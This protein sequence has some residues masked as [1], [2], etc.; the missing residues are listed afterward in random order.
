MDDRAREYLELWRGRLEA[1][2]EIELSI[3]PAVIRSTLSLLDL[4]AAG[5]IPAPLLAELQ[6]I[7]ES[8]QDKAKQLESVGKLPKVMPALDAACIAAFVAPPVSREGDDDHLPVSVIP[9]ADK[10][11]VFFRL[12]KGVE[13]LRDFHEES[14]RANGTARAGDGVPL[15]AEPDIGNS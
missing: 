13:P 14:G 10:L 11:K 9:I 6:E 7:S 1:T 12:G 3:G 4:A 5:H 8:Q 2:E 15:P